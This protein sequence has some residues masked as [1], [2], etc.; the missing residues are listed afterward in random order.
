M[1]ATGPKVS[2]DISYHLSH[3]E[4]RRCKLTEPGRIETSR[5][6]GMDAAE[7][8]VVFGPPRHFRLS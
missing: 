4:Q 3:A 8:A 7:S 5:R 6:P 2:V 1:L